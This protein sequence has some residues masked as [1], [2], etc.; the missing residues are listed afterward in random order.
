MDPTGALAG[1]AQAGCARAAWEKRGCSARDILQRT[2][3]KL[4]Q[5]AWSLRD[6]GLSPE[7]NKEVVCQY[8]LELETRLQARRHG[9]RWATMRAT[10]EDLYRFARYA[11]FTTEDD[12]RYLMNRLTRYELLERGQDAL[13]FAALLETGN[14]TLRIL[15]QADRILEQAAKKRTARLAIGCAT[16]EL[17]W[18]STV[19][20]P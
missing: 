2:C 12:R 14:T 18:V 7:L 13:K 5:L 4:C 16:L 9:I 19:S 3:E 17:S 6:S 15:D 20:S 1:R 11:D 10:V 8:L